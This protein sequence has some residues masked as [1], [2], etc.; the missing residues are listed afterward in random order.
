D[1]KLPEADRQGVA[2]HLAGCAPC[3]D[4]LRALAVFELETARVA[5]PGVVERKPSRRREWTRLVLHPALAY[6]LVLALLFYPALR[7]REDKVMYAPVPPQ[8]APVG[9]TFYDKLDAPSREEAA[10]GE[11]ERRDDA[12]QN[13]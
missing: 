5:R 8:R 3:R 9:E 2:R 11:Q 7:R 4:E 6:G 12:R 1:A 10:P 13:L